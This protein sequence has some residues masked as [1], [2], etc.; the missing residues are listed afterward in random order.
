L[1]SHISQLTTA[2]QDC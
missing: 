1:I 2:N